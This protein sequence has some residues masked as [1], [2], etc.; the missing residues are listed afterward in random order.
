MARRGQG[1]VP[2]AP[3]FHSEAPEEVYELLTDVVGKLHSDL[4][5]SE[6][7]ILFKHNGWKS[8]GKVVFA[9]IKILG[10]D[11]RTTM[12]K[13]FI[14]F[15]N[16]DFWKTLS[17]PQKLYILDHQLSTIDV[18]TDKHDDPKTAMDGR[19]KLKSLPHDI[20]A[21]AA[22]IKRHGAIMED[23]KR[24]ALSLKETNQL[25]I[26]DVAAAA[27]EKTPE[28]PREGVKGTI[29]DDGTINLEDDPNQ[30][31]LEEVTGAAGEA[32]AGSEGSAD[33]GTYNDVSQK[34]K[35]GDNV[36]QI[37][38]RRGKKKEEEQAPPPESSDDE[39]EEIPADDLPF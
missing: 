23:V 1:R 7:L 13:D 11:L 25:T 3:K 37:S 26:E 21:Y 24:L 20:E 28:E 32:A 18:T 22:V 27:E 19:P 34:I 12:N 29:N 2:A 5:D 39:L 38:S 31:K 6:P 15:L 9:K 17:D 14:L 16:A 4:G 33:A 10:D 8:K 35:E 30:V 36:T